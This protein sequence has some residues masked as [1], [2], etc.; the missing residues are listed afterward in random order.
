MEK[1][2]Q[3]FVLKTGNSSNETPAIFLKICISNFF[4]ER[5]KMNTFVG[6]ETILRVEINPES[7]IV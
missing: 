7:P 5:N 6:I 4:S 3:T 1:N 2:M